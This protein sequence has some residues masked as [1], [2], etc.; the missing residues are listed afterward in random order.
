[1][2]EQSRLHP[3]HDRVRA[4]YSARARQAPGLRSSAGRACCEEYPAPILEGIPG[5]IASASLGCGDPVSAAK[6]KEGE[7][8]LDLGSGGGLD[9]F[10]AARLVGSSGRVIGIDMTGDMLAL[11]RANARK[12]GFSNVEFRRG[13]IEDLPVDDASVDAV[14]SNCVINLSPDKAC[15]IKEIHRVL[16]PGGRLAVSDIVTRGRLKPK[17]AEGEDS[18]AGCVAGAL[19]VASYLELLRD[20]GFV[21]CSVTP[22]GEARIEDHPEGT[23]FSAI[24]RGSR[25]G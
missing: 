2:T 13:L 24:I 15:V 23:P 21:D 14:L 22:L 4:H 18:W 17:F 8:V 25:P 12:L 1:M 3:I 9:C 11:A 20:A 10:L 5:E 19:S 7:V 16:R 6:L